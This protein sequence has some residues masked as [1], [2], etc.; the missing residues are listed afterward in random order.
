MEIP[1]ELIQNVYALAPTL[2]AIPGIVAVGAGFR[3]EN[4]ELID[5]LAVRVLVRDAFA[6]PDGIPVAEAGCA[7]YRTAPIPTAPTR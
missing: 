3:E 5:D 4:G 1:V 7:R 6:L 2:T